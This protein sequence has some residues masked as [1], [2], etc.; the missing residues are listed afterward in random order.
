MSASQFEMRIRTHV[1]AIE[2]LEPLRWRVRID[3]RTFLTFCSE[4]RARNA[5]RLEARRLDFVTVEEA[6]EFR[7]AP[8][9]GPPAD[10]PGPRGGTGARPR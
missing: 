5:A 10:E 6:R 4:A 3:G 9:M 2:R 1:V 7:H 8:A